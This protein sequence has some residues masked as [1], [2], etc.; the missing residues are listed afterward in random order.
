MIK[1]K[2]KNTF[3]RLYKKLFKL[4]GVV[5]PKKNTLVIFESFFGKSYS[6]NPRAIY[7]YLKQHHPEL[8]LYWSADRRHI[9]TFKKYNLKFAT[10]FSIK[11]LFLMTRAKYW[12]VNSRMPLWIPKPKQTIYVQTWHGTPLKKLG[13][14]I[15]HV[16]MP[17]TNT[18]KYK[19]NF[20]YEASKWDYLIS[21][22]RY[23][24]EIFRRAFGFKKTIIESGYPRNDFLINHNNEGTITKL[25]QKSGL[26]LDKKVILYAPT[27]RDN[28]FYSK[29]KYKFDLQ[30][31]LQKLQ[32]ALGDSH[33]FLLRLHYLVAENLDLSNYENFVYDFSNH[34]DIRELYL[35]SDLLITDYSSVFFDYA[36]L[37][38]PMLFF[39]YDIENYRDHL[40]G[41]YFDF[42]NNAPGP[43]IKTTD[44]LI[45]KIQELEITEVGTT[46]TF[47]DFYSKFCSLEDGN[48]SK[49]V[50]K[51]I[52]VDPQTDF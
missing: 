12:V 44:E 21:P 28:Q 9:D 39:V 10:R 42:V 31:N 20:L 19:K 51:K 17:G 14:D 7:E 45:S 47:R 37:K 41:F 27:W 2:L 48:A 6:D 23:S 25:K 36:N 46:D 13:V 29:G 40:R 26:P 30:L 3:T 50:I 34:N 49:R 1:T 15:E 38:R 22:N 11:W 52:F 16:H 5:L 35:M 4:F 43:L 8:T 33:I 24:T 32:S 18:E